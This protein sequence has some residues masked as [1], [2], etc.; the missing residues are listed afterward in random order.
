M[1]REMAKGKILNV[2]FLFLSHPV[3]LTVFKRFSPIL[4]IVNF[5]AKKKLLF[6]LLQDNTQVER[7]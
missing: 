4:I 6:F 7:K 1:L 5:M 2:G 3:L